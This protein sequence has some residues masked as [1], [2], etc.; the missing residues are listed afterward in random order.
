M[1]PPLAT[2]VERSSG[3]VRLNGTVLYCYFEV[4]SDPA[5]ARRTTNGRQWLI[6]VSL[7]EFEFL[8][9]H[10]YERV[11]IRLHLRGEAVAYLTTRR[12]EPPFVWLRFDPTV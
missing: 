7:D 11:S 1:H 5:S 6:R 2:A 9:V 4:H 10:L 12:D 8:G 3:P